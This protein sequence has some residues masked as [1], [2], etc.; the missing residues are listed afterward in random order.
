MKVWAGVTDENGIATIPWIGESEIGQDETNAGSCLFTPGEQYI[1][2]QTLTGEGRALPGGSWL[3]SNA[4]ITVQQETGKNHTPGITVGVVSGGKNHWSLVNYP[5]TLTVNYDANGGTFEG[6]TSQNFTFAKDKDCSTELIQETVPV[7][8]GKMFVGWNTRADGKGTDYFPN[9]HIACGVESSVTLYAI[10]TEGD[11]NYVARVIANDGSVT[12]HEN[13]V[14]TGSGTAQGAFNKAN[15]LTGNVAIE[16]LRETSN[17][18]T[19]TDA[20]TLSKTNTTTL[21]TTQNKIWNPTGFTSVIARGWSGGTGATDA[22]FYVNGTN[23]ITRDI[24]FDGG[25]DE[26]N[27]SGNT[28]RCIYISNGTISIQNGTTIRN[29]YTDSDGGAV[30]GNGKPVDVKVSAGGTALF[31]NCKANRGGAIFATSNQTVRVE[32]HGTVTFNNCFAATSSGGAIFS[33]NSINLKNASFINCSATNKGGA[34]SSNG[35]R[36][37]RSVTSI[38]QRRNEK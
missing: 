26:Q 34:A 9:G 28:G 33:N 36:W 14:G 24:I 31:D 7:Q 25:R 38:I 3:Y 19:L 11:N 8:A 20:V 10:W 1:I 21:S 16:L 13:L 2:R 35:G 12:Y 4:G 37:K 29:F 6:E 15:S 32:S 5:N 30:Y 23:F 22:M 27:T 17:K 18:Y